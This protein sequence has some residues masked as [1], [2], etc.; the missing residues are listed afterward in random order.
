M[1]PFFSIQLTPN[2]KQIWSSGQAQISEI[3][4]LQQKT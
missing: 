1:Y 2:S 3:N 4:Y